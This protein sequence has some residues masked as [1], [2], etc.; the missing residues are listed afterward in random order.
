L[1]QGKNSS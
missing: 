1:A